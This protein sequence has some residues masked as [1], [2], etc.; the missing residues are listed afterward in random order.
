MHQ[1]IFNFNASF[2]SYLDAQS[3]KCGYANY[4]NLYGSYP[5][6]GPFPT[7]F[8]DLNNIPYECDLWSAIFNAALIINPAFNIYR[9]TDTP[10]I[11]W[12]VLG[13][14]GSF[15]NQQSPIY[16]NRS[17]VQTVIHAP[18]IVWTECSTSNVFVN[19]IDQ[20]PAPA[21]SVLPNVIEKSHRTII[22][23]GQHDFRI[24]AEGT[25]LTIQN[26]TWHGMQ[27][28]QTK[29]FFRFVVPGQGDLGF[30]HTER[31]LT[32]GEIVLSGHMVPQFQPRAAL[33]IL[34]LLLGRIVLENETSTLST[35]PDSTT[36]HAQSNLAFAV[37]HS[38]ACYCFYL[39]FQ[40]YHFLR[41]IR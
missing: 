1:N 37:M 40:M 18:N 28:F 20:S 17:D 9:I 26:M 23:N 22:V 38:S 25:S 36:F 35:S 5:P 11:L 39:L 24:I 31:G 8:T 13:F 29:P 16:F 2:L 12:D 7:L 32:Y 10:P 19:G 15:P 21:L 4:S 14:P 27:G 41:I 3:V 6:A 30:I 34:Q 33:Q